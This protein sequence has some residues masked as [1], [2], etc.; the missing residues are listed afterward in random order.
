MGKE[1]QRLLS[2]DSS[3]GRWTSGL[4]SPVVSLHGGKQRGLMA[5]EGAP[6]DSPG[7]LRGQPSPPHTHT[8]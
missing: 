1:T 4:P 5:R 3:P 6:R 7:G 8:E 2:L